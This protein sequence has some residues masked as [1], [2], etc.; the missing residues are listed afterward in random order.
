MPPDT[1]TCC[2]RPRERAATAPPVARVPLP[3]SGASAAAQRAG[4][5]ER[6]RAC[7]CGGR[8]GERRRRRDASGDA[9]VAS[10]RRRACA[11]CRPSRLER[12]DDESRCRARPRR[13]L[14]ERREDRLADGCAGDLPRRRP[15]RRRRRARQ[16]RLL[17]SGRR[18][19]GD[20]QAFARGAAAGAASSLSAQRRRA[21]A[22]RRAERRARPSTGVPAGVAPQIKIAAKRAGAGAPRTRRERCA[23]GRRRARRSERGARRHRRPHRVDRPPRDDARRG[24]RVE[25]DNGAPLGRSSAGARRLPPRLRRI[26]GAPR[27]RR[28]VV[29]RQ[30]LAAGAPSWRLALGELAIERGR[31]GFVDRGCGGAGRARRPRPRGPDCAASPS[32]ARPRRRSTSRR[33]SRCR[34]GRAARRS[35]AA[36]S[37]ASTPAA[38]SPASPPA[39]RRAPRRRCSS[40]TCRCTCSIP[41]STTLFDID[42]QKA[43]TSFKGDVRWARVG[44]GSTLARAR[45]RDDRRLS[46]H[47]RGHRPGRGSARAGDDARRL[48][49]PPAAQLEVAVAARHRACDGAGRGDPVQRRRDGAERLLRARR[50]RRE[51]PPQPAGRR[52]GVP[53]GEPRRR[54]RAPAPAST[55]AAIVKFGPIA[56][57]GG[58]V[59]YNDRFV[60]P[61]YN[62]NL[63]ELSGR[64]AAFSSEPPAPGQ[65]PQLAELDAARPRRGHRVARDQRQGEPA[66]QAAGARP[67]G[68]G[69]RSRAA[70]AV[71]LRDQVLGLRHRARQDERRPRLRRAAERRA[72]GD[73]QDRPATSSPSATR[74]KARPRACRSSWPS[75]CS[76]T[77]M[78]S[79]TSTCP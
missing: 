44:A 7:E 28:R 22:R 37:A 47:Q 52:A 51:R 18:G 31:V 70:A 77:G 75:R 42:V 55:P 14:A 39:C 53:D 5:V 57:V 41:T 20:G 29:R 33:A 68:Q 11:P 61:N 45:R 65:P 58:R 66:R 69:A 35:A 76:P 26:D 24:L 17:R 50:P 3:T 62:A 36:S 54:C 43:Q 67:Q 32:T 1:S 64:L 13:L 46:R 12:R 56:V 6:D 21:A 30:A 8:F 73:E 74:S 16:A 4:C 63:S 71:A 34:P 72:D 60:K 15:A 38:S 49:R 9:V 59:N 25:R 79:S 40:R 10:Q 78:A 48:G 19:R 2:S 23:R 27:R